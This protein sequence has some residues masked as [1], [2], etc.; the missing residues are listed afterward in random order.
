[1]TNELSMTRGSGGVAF[2]SPCLH[3][4]EAMGF[5]S[6]AIRALCTLLLCPHLATADLTTTPGAKKKKKDDT[7]YV[8][9]AKPVNVRFI[10]GM[11]VD[12]ELDAATAR[13]G[14]VRFVIRE[15][16]QHGTLSVIRP[17]P[18]ESYKAIVTYT[19]NPGDTALVDRFT[20]ACKLEES[21]WSAPSPVSLIGKRANPKVEIIQPPSFGKVLPGFES[22]SKIILK[23]TGIAPFAADIQWQVPWLGPPRIEL[24][25]GEQK[26]YMI[27][28]KPTAPGTLIWEAELQHGEPLSKVRLYVECAQLFVVAPGQLKLLYDDATGARRG[29][30]GVANSTDLPMKFTIEPPAG[31]KAPKEI[32]VQPKQSL[33]VEVSLSPDNVNAFRGELWVINEPYRERV[34]LDAAPEPPQAV[35]V[36]PKEAVIDFGTLQKGKSAQAKIVLKN[37]GGESAVLAA[38]AAPPFRV[39]ES[40]AAVSIAPGESREMIVE[41]AAEGAGK[42]AGDIIFSGT[43]GK[44]NVA[45]K[46]VVNDPSTP[47]PIRPMSA[48]AARPVRV[49]VAKAASAAATKPAEKPPEAPK[50]TTT[51][52]D[53]TVETDAQEPA[54]TETPTAPD[55]GLAPLTS[56][57][58]TVFAYLG[59]HGMPTWKGIQSPTLKKPGGIE[60]VKQGRD[61]LVLAWSEPPEKPE[62]YLIEQG[63]PVLN[64][65]TGRWLKAWKVV[66]NVDKITGEDGKHTVRLTKL[67]PDS[68][69]ELRFLGF[70]KNGKVSEPSDTHY[71]STAP[72]WR[73]P[74]WTWQVL[75]AIALGIFVFVY[76]RIKRGGWDL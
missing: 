1:M 28:V 35:L 54:S 62:G 10:G 50:A 24:G 30:V 12:I 29:K 47:Q 18:K 69:Y 58:S 71:I 76:F 36:S 48:Q 66:P 26:E 60:L 31:V 45:A 56:Y 68:R 41:V 8:P 33:D 49:P 21:S 52:P 59:T 23:N 9:E 72:P 37:I 42:F 2:A 67:T 3:K 55:A 61:F 15:Q 13:T 4:R 20:Y 5:Y 65:P 51:K 25:I 70:D 44:L 11:A 6:F 32:E 46:L 16:P 34:L 43:G 73:F 14:A 39:I 27:T 74:P 40:D 7:V 63:Y 64:K 38:Q 57:Q 22:S 75:V 53:K 19:P 17:H